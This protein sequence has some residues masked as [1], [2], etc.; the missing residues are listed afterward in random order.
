MAFTPIA[1]PS[2][3]GVGPRT[4]SVAAANAGDIILVSCIPLE[5]NVIDIP[6]GYTLYYNLNSNMTAFYRIADGTETN[7]TVDYVFPVATGKLTLNVIIVRP[8]GSVTLAEIVAPAGGSAEVAGSDSFLCAAATEL[9]GLPSS[10]VTVLGYTSPV[11]IP[12]DGT[13]TPTDAQLSLSGLTPGGPNNPNGMGSV[14]GYSTGVID[15]DSSFTYAPGVGIIA[16]VYF[17]VARWEEV[18]TPS[19]SN[20]VDVH[21]RRVKPWVPPYRLGRSIYDG[22]SR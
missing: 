18:V 16:S 14:I 9:T 13:F 11:S 21:P 8:S 20:H 1:F 19:L 6:V 4:V 12:T 10:F 2:S 15:S 17:A 7:L 22:R 5:N 3:T